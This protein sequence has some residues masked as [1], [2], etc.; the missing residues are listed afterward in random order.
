LFDNPTYDIEAVKR[1]N[2]SWGGIGLVKATLNGLNQI[3]EHP[4]VKVDY[5][6]LIDGADYPIASNDT[7]NEDFSIFI[8][9]KSFIEHF[10]HASC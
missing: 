8:Y 4:T 3:I 10:P 9:G 7:I 6:H 2:G 5:I 1:E